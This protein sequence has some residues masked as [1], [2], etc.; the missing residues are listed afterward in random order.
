MEETPQQPLNREEMRLRMR[1]SRLLGPFVRVEDE[2]L[3]DRNFVQAV[4]ERYFAGQPS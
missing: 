4:V 1:L 3:V 2:C